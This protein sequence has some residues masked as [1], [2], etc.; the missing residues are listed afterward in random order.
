MDRASEYREHHTSVIDKIV[1][2]SACCMICGPRL[3]AQTVESRPAVDPR[4]VVSGPRE[5]L[6]IF[7]IGESQLDRFTDGAPLSEDG[8]AT[9]IRLLYRAP[10]FPLHKLHRWAQWDVDVARLTTEPNRFRGALL[11]LSGEVTQ[12]DRTVVPEHFAQRFGFDHYFIITMRTP[13]AKATIYCRSIPEAWLSGERGLRA[14]LGSNDSEPHGHQVKTKNVRAGGWG[15][16]T[17]SPQLNFGR[18]LRTENNRLKACYRLTGGSLRSTPG[19]RSKTSAPN[20][21]PM[22][23]SASAK[24]RTSPNRGGAILA[25]GGATR[26]IANRRVTLGGQPQ[27]ASAEPIVSKPSG[28]HRVRNQR[29]LRF[30]LGMRRSDGSRPPRPMF[31]ILIYPGLRNIRFAQ[32][33]SPW[34][35]TGSPLWGFFSLETHP[36]IITTVNAL[37]WGESRQTP[38]MLAGTDG[39]QLGGW[40]GSNDSEP[41]ADVRAPSANRK[42]HIRSELPHRWG[43]AALDPSH[44]L[45]TTPPNL[46]HRWESPPTPRIQSGTNLQ[47]FSGGAVHM[48]QSDRHPNEVTSTTIHLDKRAS[49]LA[50][51][52]KVGEDGGDAP[53]IVAVA[54]TIAWHPS[55]PDPARGVSVDHVFLADYGMDIGQFAFVEDRK[56]LTAQD[57]E[58][59]YQLLDTVEK[60]TSDALGKRDAKTVDVTELLQDPMTYRGQYLTLVGTVRRAVRI[61]VEDVDIVERFGIDHY[62]ELEVFTNPEMT[63]RF[64]DD[65]GGQ[66]KVFHRYPVVVCLRALP[67]WL[68]EGENLS[69]DVRLS[70]FFLKHWAYKSQYMSEGAAADSPQRLQISPLLVG[71]GLQRVAYE[72]DSDTWGH[73]SGLLFL[74]LLLGIAFYVWRTEK[75]DRRWRRQRRSRAGDNWTEPPHF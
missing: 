27:P 18:Q 75:E 46:T 62:Y 54:N 50:M 23:S 56:P 6:E 57:R 11:K 43:L 47:Q 12:I 26:A 39:K 7:Q 29:T 71:T 13:E 44:P 68:P 24:R 42:H 51:F 30:G 52:L 63:V 3:A 33:A 45:I 72:K 58:C 8:L 38:S 10:S 64:V 2:L 1:V 17:V 40:L 31:P 67:A 20:L 60:I 48:A 55:K 5:M 37:R 41:P 32:V 35:K 16:T 34:A 53:H 19:T 36:L 9:L 4:H 22:G 28:R 66:D 49:A 61:R 25:Q 21:M 59:F 74:L 69:T 65:R 14:W 73:V 70:G 15:R